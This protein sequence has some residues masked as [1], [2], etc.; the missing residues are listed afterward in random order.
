MPYRLSSYKKGNKPFMKKLLLGAILVTFTSV[1]I[2][3]EIYNVKTSSTDDHMI[4][5]YDLR[6]EGDRLYDVKLYFLRKDSTQIHPKSL[7]G[8]IGKVE[9]GSGKTIVWD[10]YKDI[11][12]ISGS[13]TP[14]LTA[15][16]ISMPKFSTKVQDKPSPT[17]PGRIMDV[18]TKQV[19]KNK[20][21]ER[22]KVRFGIRLGV[23]KSRVTSNQRDFFFQEERSYM[24]GPYLRWNAGK[25]FY[26]QPEVL[27][28]QQ[29]YGELIGPDT[30]VIHRHN[31][32]RGQLIAGVAPIPGLYFNFGMYYQQNL[33]GY[34]YED[35]TVIQDGG[36][37][38][39]DDIGQVFPFKESE[40]GYLAGFSLSLG[41]GSFVLGWLYSRGANNFVDGNYELANEV[42][43]GQ[44]LINGSTH[45]FIQKAF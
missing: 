25:R 12:G 21:K 40:L 27:F 6:G 13:I 39:T 41:Q 2:G 22:K 37:A 18:L 9:A 33:N 8:D 44:T 36:G 32:A 31:G 1:L 30:K 16:L 15:T 14:K 7:H 5:N 43:S 29:H 11:D 23:G 38:I 28:Q 19:A 42:I 3:Q 17:A 26:L 24:V 20:N 35:L 10:V 4:I 45:F 34:A